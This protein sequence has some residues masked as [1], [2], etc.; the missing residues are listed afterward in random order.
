MA[1]EMTDVAI[2]GGGPAGAALAIWLARAGVQTTLIERREKPEWHACGVFSSPLTRARLRDLGFS[3]EEIAALNRPISAL[4]LQTTRGTSCR[5]EYEQGFAC[6]FDRVRLDEELLQR[7]AEVGANVRMSTVVRSVELPKGTSEHG[8]LRLSD[9]SGDG[10][11]DEPRTLIA[12]VIVGADGLGS[13]IARAAD[14]Y[15]KTPFLSKS[16]ITFHRS[17]PAGAPPGEAME[18]RFVFGSS[19]YVGIAP[20]PDARVNV[21]IVIPVGELTKH[22]PQTIGDRVIASLPA[23]RDAW[24]S[25]PTTDGAT[26][27]GR[28]EHHVTRAAGPGFVLVGDAIGFIDPLTGEGLQRA[29]VS[30]ELA[31]VAV[32]KWLA[33]DRSAMDVYDRRV[34]SRWRSKNAVSW[35]LQLFL[36]RPAAFDYALRR[37]ATRDDLREEL[38]LVLTDQARATRALD[39]RFLVRLLAP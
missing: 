36:A 28:L 24:M 19:W 3:V 18:G 39:P 1:D 33:G 10:P 29:F 20:V 37:L 8:L 32:R 14:V 13:G 12:R 16:G 9:T 2:V 27:A 17:D 25:A 23:P 26:F 30:A 6:G 22:K 35:L 34:R 38:T 11:A 31:A 5:I 21:G 4:N 7:A 15:A